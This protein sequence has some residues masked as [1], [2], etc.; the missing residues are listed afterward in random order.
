M[1]KIEH[2]EGVSASLQVIWTVLLD[3]IENPQRYMVGISNCLFPENTD[4]FAVREIHMG[5]ESAVVLTERITIDE[6]QGT[7]AYELQNHPMFEGFVYNKLIPP[8]QDDAKAL[9]VVLFEMDWKP[10]NNEASQAEAAALGDLSES[11]KLAVQH[12][13]QLAEQLEQESLQPPS[14]KS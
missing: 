13:K 11:L 2:F 4:D 6:P 8:A 7:V 14:N 10:K 9:P 5:E 1:P 3:R 12:V